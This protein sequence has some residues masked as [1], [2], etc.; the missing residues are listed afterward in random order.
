VRL[1]QTGTAYL[2]QL[3]TGLVVTENGIY[4]ISRASAALVLSAD[5]ERNFGNGCSFDET[6]DLV[7]VECNY[8]PTEPRFS[9]PDEPGNRHIPLDVAVG[10]WLKWATLGSEQAKLLLCNL[11]LAGLINLFDLTLSDKADNT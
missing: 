1:V 5:V 11:A 6:L 8:D 3:L 4:L 9:L 2:P 10:S 7:L